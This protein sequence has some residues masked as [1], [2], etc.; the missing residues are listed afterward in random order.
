ML[1]VL[2]KPYLSSTFH[3][4]PL[5][6]D[7]LLNLTG[8]FSIMDGPKFDFLSACNSPVM[9]EDKGEFGRTIVIAT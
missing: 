9:I 6:L 2:P 4:T 8:G 3:G 1:V 7:R 5:L